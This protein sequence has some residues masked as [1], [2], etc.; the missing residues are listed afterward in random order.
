MQFKCP[1]CEEIIDKVNY[2]C[3][4]SGQEYGDACI[5]DEGEFTD[6][7]HN[8]SNSND[9]DNYIYQCP[10][11]DHELDQ[12]ELIKVNDDKKTEENTNED[13]KPIQTPIVMPLNELISDNS[14]SF[15]QIDSTFNND[16]VV[17][18]ECGE[19][20]IIDENEESCACSNCDTILVRTKI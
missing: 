4:T 18:K 15:F 17:C 8:D 11:C 19:K 9:S 20:N 5:D 16:Y 12:S 14:Q 10:E 6:H 13:G 2:S 1:Y 7:R 3:D